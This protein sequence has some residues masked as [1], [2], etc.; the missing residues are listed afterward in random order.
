MGITHVFCIRDQAVRQLA[1]GVIFR[2]FDI[3]RIIFRCFV[4]FPGA[5]MD[6]IDIERLFEMVAAF[7]LFHPVLILP[8]VFEVPDDGR[9]LRALLGIDRIRICLVEQFFSGRLDD[10]FVAHA[11][12]RPFDKT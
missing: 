1:V 11:F 9:R 6:F 12:F 8:F 5:Q 7:P 10:I 4:A 3:V 2:A